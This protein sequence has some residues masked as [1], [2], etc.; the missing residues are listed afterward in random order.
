MKVK[1]ENP[2][3]LTVMYRNRPFSL[4]YGQSLSGKSFWYISDALPLEVVSEVVPF[5][6]KALEHPEL[7]EVKM[8]INGDMTAEFVTFRRARVTRQWKS[9]QTIEIAERDITII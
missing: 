1:M 4:H 8:I 3:M 5:D 6:K 9:G 7:V 2:E